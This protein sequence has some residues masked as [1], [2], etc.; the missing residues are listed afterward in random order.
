MD[1]HFGKQVGTLLSECYAFAQT[2]YGYADFSPG[3]SISFHLHWKRA[4]PLVCC[5]L[6]SHSVG[7]VHASLSVC[8]DLTLHVVCFVLAPT[9]LVCC[10]YAQNIHCIF[11]FV[12][13]TCKVVCCIFVQ[14]HLSSAV[15]SSEYSLGM[16]CFRPNSPL[17]LMS[18]RP[19]ISLRMLSLHLI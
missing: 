16:L 8:C 18:F 7:C 4:V 1:D 11:Y 3:H 15:I 6:A 17:K 14:T 13:L 10:A 12:A 9:H 2:T 5:V 19:S